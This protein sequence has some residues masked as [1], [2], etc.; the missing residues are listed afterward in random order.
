MLMRDF[1][2]TRSH[3]VVGRTGIMYV[4]LQ[5]PI[6]LCNIMCSSLAYVQRYLL[7]FMGD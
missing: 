1:F 3:P 7:S 6:I 2:G 5:L 4:K